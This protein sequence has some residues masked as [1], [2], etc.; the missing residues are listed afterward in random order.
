MSRR[1]LVL[2]WFLA[3]SLDHA[4]GPTAPAK[5]PLAAADL[6]LLE[7]AL[8][9]QISPDG[10][11]VVYVRRWADDREDRWRGNLWIVPSTGGDQRPLTTGARSDGSPRWSPDGT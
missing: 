5:T 1:S 8:D 9:P 6:F 2:V 10:E 11:S 3:S 7:L 4:G